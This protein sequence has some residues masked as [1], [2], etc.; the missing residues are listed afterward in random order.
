MDTTLTLTGVKK[1]VK[2]PK[3]SS[4]TCPQH[5]KNSLRRQKKSQPVLGRPQQTQ[6][7]APRST[8]NTG[9]GRRAA[10]LGGGGRRWG[11]GTVAR[12]FSVSNVQQRFGSR[13]L[14]LLPPKCFPLFSPKVDLDHLRTSR[15]PTDKYAPTS[16]EKSHRRHR[17]LDVPASPPP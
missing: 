11:C 14:Q 12:T 16:P 7:G 3:P 2:N 17:S 5:R 4:K 15:F 10:V 8:W 13:F 1:A 6:E 9:G